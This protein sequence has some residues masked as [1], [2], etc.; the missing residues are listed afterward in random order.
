MGNF[1]SLKPAFLAARNYWGLILVTFAS[2]LLLFSR[3]PSSEN[4]ILNQVLQL[5]HFFL[6]AVFCYLLCQLF[7]RRSNRPQIIFVVLVGSFLSLISELLQPLFQ[8]NFEIQDIFN[9]LLGV[10]CGVCLYLANS[11]RK[12]KQAYRQLAF[13]RSAILAFAIMLIA[14]H[15]FISHSL[16]QWYINQTPNVIASFERNSE[17]LRWE[18]NRTRTE[19]TKISQHSVLKVEFLPAHYPTVTLK[20]FNSNWEKFSA[21]KFRIFNPNQTKVELVTKIYDELHT[22]KGFK[23]SDRMNKKIT[24]VPGWNQFEIPIAEIKNSP[25]HR[26][27]AMD[28]IASLSFFLVDNK[29]SLSLYFDS[30]ELAP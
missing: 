14:S 19:L 1:S 4:R 3:L 9:D 15:S 24:I 13:W 8:R 22:Q 16:D 21:F 10:F 26:L 20:Y 12:Q 7:E 25:Q 6:F 30:L 5:G 2:P 18:N 27:M 29:A 17:A 28:N 11:A 23:F